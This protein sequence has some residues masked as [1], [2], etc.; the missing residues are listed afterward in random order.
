MELVH[1]SAEVAGNF[2]KQALAGRMTLSMAVVVTAAVVYAV[3]VAA[4]VLAK[5]LYGAVPRFDN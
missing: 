4:F 5:C 3:E 1:S 2:G